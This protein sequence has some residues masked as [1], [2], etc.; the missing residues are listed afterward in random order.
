MATV[1]AADVVLLHAQD[2]ICVATRNLEKGARVQ[3]GPHMLTLSESV[4]MGH[5]VATTAIGTGQPVRKY[6]QIIGLATGAIRPGEWVHSHNLENGDFQRDYAPSSEVPPDPTPIADRT[7]QGYRRADGKAGTRNYVAVISTV[8][9]SASVS[10]YV[11]RRVE[12]TLVAQYP[13]VDGV[14]S[15]THGGGCAMQFGGLKHE[16]LNRVLGGIARHPNVGAYVLIG[17]GLWAMS[18]SQPSR[19]EGAP[20]SLP[21]STTLTLTLLHT[22]DTWG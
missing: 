22:N 19:A 21:P 2:N 20:P 11:A 5:K 17:A 13:N 7:F 8:N 16:M 3:A 15:F 18:A 12:D 6:G 14:L 10:K 9:C 1:H 4:A